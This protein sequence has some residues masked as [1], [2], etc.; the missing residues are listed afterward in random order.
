MDHAYTNGAIQKNMPEKQM[1]ISVRHPSS[2]P[3]ISVPFA[4][5]KGL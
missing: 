2:V 3:R 5:I 4:V 1:A